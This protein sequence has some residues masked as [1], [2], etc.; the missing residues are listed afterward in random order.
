LHQVCHSLGLPTRIV[1]HQMRH[2]L[3]FRIMSRTGSAA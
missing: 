3:P 1:P 2:Y